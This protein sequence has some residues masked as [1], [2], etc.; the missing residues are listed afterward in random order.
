MT[1]GVN[2]IIPGLWN[3]SRCFIRVVEF[4]LVLELNKVFDNIGR[5]YLKK[6]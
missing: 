3:Y 4:V 5:S 1:H 6:H 2:G